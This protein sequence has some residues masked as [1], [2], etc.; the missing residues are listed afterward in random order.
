MSSD[1]S[2]W[3]MET[4]MSIVRATVCHVPSSEIIRRDLRNV[5]PA[6]GQ[7]L[8]N[9]MYLYVYEAC[10]PHKRMLQTIT[11]LKSSEMVKKLYIWRHFEQK[12]DAFEEH[13][14]CRESWQRFIAMAFNYEGFLNLF[15]KNKTLVWNYALVIVVVAR[16][17]IMEWFEQPESKQ[18]QSCIQLVSYAIICTYYSARTRRKHFFFFLIKN[19]LIIGRAKSSAYWIRNSALFLSIFSIA[20]WLLRAV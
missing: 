13:L 9:I 15:S 12:S 19:Y 17:A 7:F 2:H 11:R 14:F 3:H 18:K 10:A 1:S 5:S 6:R 16:I 20:V 8:Y 4:T